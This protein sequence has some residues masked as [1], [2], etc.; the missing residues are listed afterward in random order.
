MNFHESVN[1]L[2]SI[3][4]KTISLRSATLFSDKLFSLVAILAPRTENAAKHRV[5][6][7]SLISNYVLLCNA[8]NLNALS[9]FYK[10]AQAY[11]REFAWSAELVIC[12]VPYSPSLRIFTM[13]GAQRSF[14]GEW[15]NSTYSALNIR[16]V[17]VYG[18]CNVHSM[19]SQ[20]L[21]NG[22]AEQCSCVSYCRFSPEHSH[23]P[24][25]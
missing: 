24:K 20:I 22:D 19:Y 10:D 4:V 16:R 9:I 15:N 5:H 18:R 6:R 7:V 14:K 8:V 11:I 3:V 17:H 21:N 13:C 1:T 12:D 2:V 23:L 25:C